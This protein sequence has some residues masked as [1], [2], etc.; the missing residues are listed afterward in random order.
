MP[1]PPKLHA[2]LLLYALLASL[3]TLVAAWGTNTEQITYVM[4]IYE[5]CLHTDVRSND[6]AIMQGMKDMLGIGGPYTK[7]GWSFSSW[8]LSRD[9][10]Y[11]ST[12]YNFDPTNMNYVLGIASQL[13]LPVLVHMNDGRWADCCTSNS[14]GGWNTTLL[15]HIAAQPNTTQ[16]NQNNVSF[17]HSW[18]GSDFF[19]FSRLNHVYRSYKKRNVQGS[20]RTLMNWARSQP[21]LFVGVSLDSET[22]FPS[23]DADYGYFATEEWRMWLQNKGIYGPGGEY[24]G[25]GRSPPFTSI[26]ELNAAFLTSFA[27]WDDVVPPE[28]FQ[29]GQPHSENWQQWRITL[30]DHEVADETLWLAEA[31]IPRELIYGHQTPELNYYGYGDSWSTEVAANGAGGVTMYGRNPDDFGNIVDPMKANSWNNWGVFEVN[32]LTTNFTF[33]YE[34]LITYFKEGIKIICPNAFENVTAKDQ[35]S[36]FDSPNFGN[37]FGDAIKEFLSTYGDIPR[38]LEP[39]PWN[40]GKKVY[41]LYDEFNLASKSGPSNLLIANGTSGSVPRKTIYSAVGGIITYKTQLPSVSN[42]ERLNFWTSIGILDGAGPGGG[43]SSFQLTI[44]GDPLYGVGLA[45]PPTYWIWKHWLPSLTDITRWAGQEVTIALATSGNEYY[46]WTQWGAPAIYKSTPDS[47]N[48]LNNLALHKPVEV[49][50]SGGGF[51]WTAQFLTD[52]NLEGGNIGQNGWSSRPHL[53]SSATEWAYVDLLGIENVGKVVL[54][55]RSD[56]TT[57]ESTGFPTAFRIQISD[58]AHTWK[59][60]VSVKNYP[61]A[62]AGHAQIFIFEV[63]KGRFIRVIASELGGVGGEKNYSMQLRAIEIFQG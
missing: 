20:A 53:T 44:N 5:G 30:I 50:S 41:D 61:R 52:G 32:P 62:K 56:L 37:T 6:V 26:Q 19:S 17:Y 31:G 27:S 21:D 55:S 60:L 46:G 57:A 34:T 18:Y 24:F 51:G 8:A 33:S 14:D 29:D 35:Y 15:D 3:Q 4:P 59:D 10:D 7:L 23:I 12:D 42:G 63:Q 58:D 45:L 47:A 54:F 22:L 2:N 13:K 16:V 9:V 49:S 43:I 39:P 1:L 36:L 38:H 28:T 25:Q 40:P 48:G 11:S